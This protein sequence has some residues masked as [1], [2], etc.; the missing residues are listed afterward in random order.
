MNKGNTA[1]VWHFS[2]SRRALTQPVNYTH[3]IKSYVRR[4]YNLHRTIGVGRTAGVQ[5]ASSSRRASCG[6]LV[7]WERARFFPARRRLR[8]AGS[9]RAAGGGG[10]Q[11]PGGC[12]APLPPPL[13]PRMRP[14]ARPGRDRTA[15][16]PRRP[17]SISTSSRTDPRVTILIIFYW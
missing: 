13:A 7:A 8:P 6:T 14:H 3:E 10:V 1:S 9:M 16:A 17:P 4:D 15:N 12:A 5:R 11:Q 2:Y